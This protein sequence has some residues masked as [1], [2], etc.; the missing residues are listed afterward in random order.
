MFY[1]LVIV[2]HSL[3]LFSHLYFCFHQYFSSLQR[4]YWQI[5]KLV[6]NS[7]LELVFN[8]LPIIFFQLALEMQGHCGMAPIVWVCL[9]EAGFFP[10]LPRLGHT[11]GPGLI[12]DLQ[13]CRMGP[14]LPLEWRWSLDTADSS[15][16]LLASN[17]ELKEVLKII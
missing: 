14:G 16:L 15:T 13:F 7:G 3:C 1:E 17:L 11:C 6:L 12:W 2:V 5:G 9:G 8:S 4:C 10:G